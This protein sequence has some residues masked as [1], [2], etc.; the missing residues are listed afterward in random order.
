[1]SD[2]GNNYDSENG[3]NRDC[4]AEK[5][6]ELNRKSASQCRKR[7]K[8]YVTQLE[9]RVDYLENE[10]HTLKRKLQFYEQN[11]KLNALSQKESILQYLTGKYDE[12][13]KMDALIR[14]HEDSGDQQDEL[15]KIINTIKIR[16][17]SQGFVRKQTV[18]YLLKKVIE[19]IM[20]SHVKY[21]VASCA[22]ENGYFEKARGRKLA[23]NLQAK[24]Q[25][26]KYVDYAEKCQDPDSHIWK[27]IINALGFNTEEIKM[28]KKQRSKILKLKERFSNNLS[29][30][31]K[32]KKEM[33][34]ISTELEKTLDDVGKNVQPI[35]I[36]RF[37]RYVDRI[38]HRKE[39]GVFELWG[40]KG[41]KFKVKKSKI[42]THELLEPSIEKVGSTMT[43]IKKKEKLKMKTQAQ[44]KI[45][46]EFEKSRKLFESNHRNKNSE[47]PIKLKQQLSP[48]ELG[49]EILENERNIDQDSDDE[50]QEQSQS[51]LGKEFKH[52]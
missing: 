27:E 1:M 21:M 18:N 7:R 4:S 16:Q 41:N 33:F 25:R 38:K 50:I 34:K 35:Q 26:G 37:L 3:E 28:L 30:F 17:G 6:K 23:K 19:K 15:C 5:K 10:V 11:E 24:T 14:K 44:S 39:L 32:I 12:Y 36:A 31:L 22:N 52:S 47:S 43:L 48:E 45:E 40:V 46:E 13:D 51:I 9:K 29:K 42:G 20:P 8:E 2:D 49:K